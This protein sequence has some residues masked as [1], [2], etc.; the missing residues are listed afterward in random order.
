MSLYIFAPFFTT[1]SSFSFTALVTVWTG[2]MMWSQFGLFEHRTSATTSGHRSRVLTSEC[3]KIIIKKWGKPQQSQHLPLPLKLNK[4]M[5][6]LLK[7]QIFIFARNMEM[8]AHFFKHGKPG[9]L[10]NY[11]FCAQKE[12]IKGCRHSRVCWDY[13]HGDWNGNTSTSCFLWSLK[14]EYSWAP[15]WSF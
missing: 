4:D 6:I 5:N 7:T 3:L 13:P 15:N 10:L 1:V 9:L 2:L 14:N 8:D 12:I 11:R